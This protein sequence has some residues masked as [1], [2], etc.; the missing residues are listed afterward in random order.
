MCI[1][2]R[3]R[4]Q[5]SLEEQGEEWGAQLMDAHTARPDDQA[6]QDELTRAVDRAIGTLPE[7]QRLAVIL[8]RY[9]EV[10]YED[11]AKILGLSVSAVKSQLFRAR[12]TLKEA[13]QEYLQGD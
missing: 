5:V 6:L 13:L 7:K 11:L 10:P 8:R 2:D 3:I 9:Q 4:K 1:R 12:H